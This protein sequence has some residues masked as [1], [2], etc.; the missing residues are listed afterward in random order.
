MSVPD[1]TEGHK[2][3]QY[4]TWRRRIGI[5]PEK[6]RRRSGSYCTPGSRIRYVST[7]HR[8]ANCS[9][10][11]RYVSTGQQDRQHP[12]LRQY[13]RA[14]RRKGCGTKPSLATV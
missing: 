1:M 12:T 9:S 6:K 13:R 11:I 7:A 14:R 2:L 3:C 8:T 4:R 5:A 10:S